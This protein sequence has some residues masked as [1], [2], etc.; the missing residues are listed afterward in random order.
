MTNGPERSERRISLVLL[1]LTALNC[2]F[3]IAWFWRFRGHNITMDGVNYIG[4]AR[5][6]LDGDFTASLHGYWSPVL[7]WLIAAGSLF[8]H[9]FTLLGRSI[10]IA[11]FLL[12]LPLL[13]ALTFKL[14]Q[15]HLAASLAVFWFS[16]ARGV[17]AGAVTTIQADFLLAACTLTYFLRLLVCLRQGTKLNWFLLGVIHAAAFLVKAF[18]MPWLA[19]TTALAVL[20][21][22]RKSLRSATASLL[23]AFLAPAIIWLTWGEA[24]KMKYGVFTT[25]YQL[26]ANLMVDLKRHLRHRERG[27]PYAFVDTS[28]DKYMIAETSWPALQ[29][30]TIMNPALVP[31]ILGN[32]L[33][34]V[35][36]ALK[37]V[38]ILLTPGGVLALAVGLILLTRR[39]AS[40]SPEAT[41]AWISIIS[42]GT[43]VGA[44]GMLVFDP[45]YALPI[46]PVLMAI[47]SYFL[48]AGEDGPPDRLRASSVLR[49]TALA[50]LLMSMV[51][52]TSYWASPFRTENRDF[53]I[54]C[55]HAAALLKSSQP[56]AKNL[57]SI[58]NGPYPEHGIGF[59]VGVYVAYLT[60]RNLVAMNSALPV[61]QAADDQLA[62]AVLGK[63]FDAVLIWGKPGN[64]S[65]QTIV[66]RLRSAQGVSLDEAI[67]DPTMGEVGRVV[68]FS[69]R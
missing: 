3:Q 56:S 24:L 52:F 51:F 55:Y 16:M 41:F 68:F 15:S 19:L 62:Q 32:E 11:T 17:V 65:Y 26:R 18:A 6:L 20:V 38:V 5:H 13:Y 27:D 43:L 53:Q 31:V 64:L 36:A 35:P 33:R 37:E 7:S 57:V 1:V 12:C 23:L 25:G 40:Y 67:L 22:S 46:T 29:E 2:M 44:Y 4:L 49:K 58:G 54:S 39:R 42:L 66:D 28:Y 10:T 14:W 59:E 61:G 21:S 69:R 8:T 60:D 30:F 34:N 9:D 45:R 63:K 50:L 47:A 48:V